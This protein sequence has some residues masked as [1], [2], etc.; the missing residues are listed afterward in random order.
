M[1]ILDDNTILVPQFTDSKVLLE[2]LRPLHLKFSLGL[3]PL[4]LKETLNG[5]FTVT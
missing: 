3:Y 1:I 4:T 2:E 5:K